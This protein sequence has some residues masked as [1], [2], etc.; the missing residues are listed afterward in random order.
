MAKK[1]KKYEHSRQNRTKAKQLLKFRKNGILAYVYELEFRYQLFIF[2]GWNANWSV[3]NHQT[4][5]NSSNTKNRETIAVRRPAI[6]C[7]LR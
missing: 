2:I 6:L 7:I 5:Q 4:N 3:N 1:L